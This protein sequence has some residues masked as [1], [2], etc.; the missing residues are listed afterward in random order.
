MFIHVVVN[1]LLNLFYIDE[2]NNHHH[3][4]LIVEFPMRI[5][6]SIV[7]YLVIIILLDVQARKVAN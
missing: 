6:F 7:A 3:V 4:K 2:I 5:Y 1:L